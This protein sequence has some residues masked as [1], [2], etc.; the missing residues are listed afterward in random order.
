[1]I[2]KVNTI[3]MKTKTIFLLAALLLTLGSNVNAQAPDDCVLTASLFVE[4]AKTKN[5]EGALPHYEKVVK[6]CPKYS[7]AIYQYGEKMFKYYLFEHK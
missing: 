1:M 4:P 6:E 2:N 3:N 5:Y 7:L